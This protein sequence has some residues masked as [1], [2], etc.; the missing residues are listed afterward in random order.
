MARFDAIPPSTKAAFRLV[1][2]SGLLK[3][4]PFIVIHPVP[5]RGRP[6]VHTATTTSGPRG[7]SALIVQIARNLP[8]GFIDHN[9]QSPGAD[10][11]QRIFY[12]VEAYPAAGV[13]IMVTQIAAWLCCISPLL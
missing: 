5:A 7:P 10:V 6:N 1:S 12:A 3:T 13:T 11:E 8:T 4:S 2:N 9:L